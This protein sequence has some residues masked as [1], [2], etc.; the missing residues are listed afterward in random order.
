MGDVFVNRDITNLIISNVI[1]IIFITEYYKVVVVE[2][3]RILNNVLVLRDNLMMD[4][5]YV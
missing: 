3:T 1:L 5:E 2:E 4:R